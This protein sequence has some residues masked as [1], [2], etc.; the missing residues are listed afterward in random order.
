MPQLVLE[1]SSNVIEKEGVQDLLR[2]FHDLLAE[3]LPTDINSC[4]SRAIEHEHYLVGT[5]RSANCFVHVTLR[6]LPGRTKVALDEV[7]KKL[8][9]AMSAHFAQSAKT[10]KLQVTLEIAELQHYFK[11][12]I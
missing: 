1:Y 11:I 10:M 8:T 6:V 4:K 7:G 9:E 2:R 3:F 12:A 5:S